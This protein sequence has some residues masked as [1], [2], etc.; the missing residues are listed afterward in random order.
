MAKNSDLLKTTL[1]L[2]SRD[3]KRLET[4]YPQRGSLSQIVRKLL[5]A[6]LSRLD[7]RVRLR[8]PLATEQVTLEE[9]TP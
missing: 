4:Y 1:W 8:Q 2:S 7:E 5:S 3:Q 9:Q 6:H